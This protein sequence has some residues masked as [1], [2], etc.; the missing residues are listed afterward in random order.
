[1][2]NPIRLNNL[3]FKS[4]LEPIEE[5]YL[6][7]IDKIFKNRD[8]KI[9]TYRQNNTC[10]YTPRNTG[11]S[12]RMAR[13][14]SSSSAIRQQRINTTNS[15]K[16]PR[17]LNKDTF[18]PNSQKKK[19]SSINN[20]PIL[21]A[22][23]LASFGILVTTLPR[24]NSGNEETKTTEATQRI[25]SPLFEED[26]QMTEEE[27]VITTNAQKEKQIAAA[28]E[29]IKNDPELKKAYHDMIVTI[30]RIGE[31]IENPVETI[32]E[33]LKQPWVRDI[34][35][36]L[37][38]PQIFYESS[39]FHYD[40]NGEVKISSANCAGYTQ[41]SEGAQTDVNRVYF[42]DNPQDR[43]DPVDNINLC[44]GLDQLLLDNYFEDDLFNTICAYN[45]GA[46]NILN[47]DYF[48]SDEYATRILNCREI[49]KANPMFTQ[50][51]LNGDLDEYV[52][53]FIYY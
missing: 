35:I 13:P 34:D 52:D 22:A 28:V 50:M 45:A 18:E 46:G 51:L 5:D 42:S 15:N 31:I 44:I 47:G 7:E 11:S 37:I 29:T 48:G 1:M 6:L 25:E 10:N 16:T 23:T 8:R 21:L 14:I 3:N 26:V 24:I 27:L 33:M 53:E 4:N 38:L 20:I 49:L 32:Q 41:I 30:Q 9:V 39:G 2:I 43:F 17:H 12:K 19:K 40:E 36:E